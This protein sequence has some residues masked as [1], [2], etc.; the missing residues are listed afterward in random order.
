[1]TSII[2]TIQNIRKKTNSWLI[3]LFL[4]LRTRL[5]KVQQMETKDVVVSTITKFP[6]PVEIF[7]EQ[8]WRKNEKAFVKLTSST[9]RIDFEK[10]RKYYSGDYLG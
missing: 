7:Y 3:Q 2:K 4:E 5:D 9:I 6:S 10:N 1:M 8:L